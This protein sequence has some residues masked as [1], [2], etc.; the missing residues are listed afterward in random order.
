MFWICEGVTS[1]RDGRDD[2]AA[3]SWPPPMRFLATLGFGPR[4]RAAAEDREFDGAALLLDEV[5]AAAP[6]LLGRLRFGGRAASSAGCRRDALLDA[7]D[8]RA[9][10]RVGGFMMEAYGCGCE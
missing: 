4:S 7:L 1:W 8:G 9:R 3:A 6:P 2:D 5:F 10:F